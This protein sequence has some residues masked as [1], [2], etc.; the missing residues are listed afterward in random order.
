MILIIFFGL[1]AVIVFTMAL[2][3]AASKDEWRDKNEKG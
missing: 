2:C 1:I 3:K